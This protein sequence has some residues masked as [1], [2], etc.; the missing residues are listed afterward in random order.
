METKRPLL[1]LARKRRF[2]S[3]EKAAGMI[4]VDC[5]TLA[6]W[7]RGLSDPQP[8]NLERLCQVYEASP[9]ELGL[10]GPADGHVHVVEEELSHFQMQDLTLRLMRL[11]WQWSP[12]TATYNDLQMQVT[13]VLKDT[14]HDPT[15]RDALHRLALLPI[16]MSGLSLLRALKTPPERDQ[17]AQIAAGVT[18]CWHLRKSAEFASAADTVAK[19][20]PVL[21][22][23]FQG[24]TYRKAATELLAQCYLLKGL[25][26]WHV[27]TQ[28]E[29]VTCA[30][31]AA[32]YSDIAHNTV[33]Q[34]LALR[35]QGA[36]H[37][38]AGHVSQA[39]AATQQAKVLMETTTV[40]IPAMV[41]SYVYVGLAT[42]Q[43]HQQ[44][45]QEAL[46]S[47]GKA[48][49]TFFAHPA[50]EAVPIWIDHHLSNLTLNDGMTHY[51]LGMQSEAQDSLAQIHA[52]P[53]SSEAIR[54][55]ATL[56]EVRTEIYRP[57]DRDMDWC[58]E[59]WTTGMIG[60]K[61]L[62]SEQ[63]FREALYT[64][65]AM[66]AAWPAEP[67]IKTLREHITHW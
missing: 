13:E 6:R 5:S 34:I 32:M 22:R 45:K 47:L 19:Y 64:Y 40:P 43:A 28:N 60:A 33:L 9:Q 66:Q 61:T 1:V 4:G 41:Q 51:H 52:N 44:Q 2:W 58:V 23:I 42:Y 31:Q 67:R 39:L 50:D 10:A 17:L 63:R 48:H 37:Y 38:Y 18:A 36:A 62:Q 49:A 15:R 30:Q 24:S 65:A 35:T 54:V 55:E 46:R 3:L 12:R 20:I 11:V 57:R 53:A 16:E 56:D 14:M 25:L 29:A 59:K 8:V 7:E 27:Q 26:A 21:K